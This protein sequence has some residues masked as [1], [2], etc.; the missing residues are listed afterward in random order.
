VS[1]FE[2]VFA[3][4]SKDHAVA[5]ASFDDTLTGSR[6]PLNRTSLCRRPPGAWRSRRPAG[7]QRV[8]SITISQWMR[9]ARSPA[10]S[11]GSGPAAESLLPQVAFR[12]NR[13][14]TIQTQTN[15]DEDLL[16]FIVSHW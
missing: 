16:H 12:P 9:T 15:P 13:P 1:F 7:S 10:S 5:V 4:H 8:R 6:T 11:T 3:D 14:W 2:S